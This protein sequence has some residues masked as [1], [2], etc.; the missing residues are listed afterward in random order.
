MSRLIDDVRYGVRILLKSPAFT[1]VAVSS[2]A[3][4]IG[5]NTTLFSAVDAVLL[6]PKPGTG[7][8]LVEVFLSDSSGYPYGASSYPDYLEYRERADVFDEV[9]AFQTVLARY[10]ADGE[11]QFVM[12]E[13]VSG[14]FFSTFGI[15]PPLGREL[16]PDDDLDPGA[17]PVV[18]VSDAF[19]RSELGARPDAPGQTLQLNGRPY[20]IL[21]V[22]SP[23]FSGSLPGLQSSFWAPAA[24]V[25]H[26][27][28]MNDDASR[29]ERRTSR[30]WF[31]RARL[32]PGVT[33]ETAQ[34]RVEAISN[35]L[36]EE[37]PDAYEDRAIQLLPSAEVRVHPMVD[38]ALF[39]VASVLMGLV[40]VVLVIACANV[41]SM[42]LAR[43]TA[44]REE[45]GIRLALGST[46]GRLV[47]QL[48]T[49]SVL[50]S[51][52]GG[53]L[54]LGVAWV[55]MKLLLALRPPIPVPLAL[56]LTLSPRVLLFTLG[57]SVATGVLFGLAPALR[58]TH[59]G[60]VLG[61]SS[62]R[63]GMPSGR[64]ARL[65]G[66]L[67][68]LQIAASLVLLIG[69]G[70][71]MRSVK[72][73]GA[74]DPGFETEQVFM[75][76]THLGLHGYEE[77]R[78]RAFFDEALERVGSLP[79]V[80]RAALAD[81]VPLG[82]GISTRTI[83]PEEAMPERDADWPELD[84]T[85]VSPGFFAV[86]DVPLLQGRDFEASDGPGAPQVVILNETAA[87]R[88]WPG[89]S[90][91]G[92]RV[93]HGAR[94]ASLEVV[95]VVRDIKMRTLGEDARPQVYFPYAQDY[96]SLM[97]VVGRSR[98][99]AAVALTEARGAMLELEPTLAFFESRTMAQNLEIPMF[100]V[101]MG[102]LLLSVFGALALTLAAVG[103]YG[104]V[105]YSVSRRTREFGVRMAL[106][107]NRL[108]IARLVARQGV[109]LVSIG[110]AFGLVL[111]IAGTRVLGS[112]L[113]GVGA[114]DPVTFAVAALVLLSAAVGAHWVPARRAAGLAPVTALRDE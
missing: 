69:A 88:F 28:P 105:A 1:F 97:Y 111:S 34:A 102:A 48:L 55:S 35:A 10:R 37:F 89:E 82:A 79:S 64:G 91:L 92:R 27:N 15:A 77:P 4:G 3:L 50:L 21:G 106:G 44:R 107:A 60:A 78:A 103:I 40:S 36:Q 38:G 90:A 54:G 62:T 63:D 41:A 65:R 61:A 23:R 46:R 94:S 68:V 74:I 30:S 52:L 16:A 80:E 113:Y 56:D 99:D 87:R 51:G 14:N 26:L 81:K 20:T 5:F 18:V 85:T 11:S 73:A 93:K 47:R 31:V 75:A 109:W 112:V 42:L 45:V 43:A 83:A 22:A 53:A 19:W 7:P 9:V 100:P 49:E 12:G 101:R 33:L 72:Q 84:S 70:L 8:E 58:A 95:G 86:M 59:A 71:M 29:L 114:T 96:S 98:A 25:D 13:V 66:A 24:M 57:V 110:C 6:S 17:H 67:V 104:V 32:A 39:P 76:S 108:D 2:L